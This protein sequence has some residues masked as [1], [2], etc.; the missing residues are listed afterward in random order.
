[1]MVNLTGDNVTGVFN[2]GS[3]K[4]TRLDDVILWASQRYP[5]A[6]INFK[7]HVH[8]D[9]TRSLISIQKYV[10]VFGQPNMSDSVKDYMLTY[11]K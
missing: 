8:T 1:M 2:I 10:S 4:S 6:V 11:R 9:V 3:G 5:D 7:K